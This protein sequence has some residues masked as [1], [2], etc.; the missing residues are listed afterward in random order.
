[1]RL[2]HAIALVTVLWFA[3]YVPYLGSHEIRG[4]EPRRILPARTMLQN[5]DF[6]VPRVGGEVYSR[7]P[8]LINWSIA[9]AFVITGDKV[10]SARVPSILWLLAFSV[11]TVIALQK[12][13]GVWRATM[14]A[15]LFLSCFG[16]LDKGRMA[17][18][19]AMYVAQTG[20]AFV[21]WLRW[22]AD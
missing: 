15:L 13:F 10:W 2:W 11:I 22:W 16:V 19:E 9:A 21:L 18:I 6:V 17:E 8:P 14:V 3:M 4:E 20:I 1:M 7:K 12:Q 5:G